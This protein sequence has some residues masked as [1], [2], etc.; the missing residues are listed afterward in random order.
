MDTMGM[1]LNAIRQMQNVL[2]LATLLMFFAVLSGCTPKKEIAHSRSFEEW[3]AKAETSQPSSP[4]APK[5]ELLLDDLET[6][7]VSSAAAL[8][9]EPNEQ[10]QEQRSL[11]TTS[12]SMTMRNTDVNVILRSLAQVTNQNMMMNDSVKG[13]AQINVQ[14]TPWDQVFKGIL[15]TQGLTYR[16]EGDILRVMSLSDLQHENKLEEVQQM[17]QA[18]ALSSKMV[19]PMLTKVIPLRF[20]SIKQLE[21]FTSIENT[22]NSSDSNSDS[23]DGDAD[24]EQVEK[25]FSNL[26]SKDKD[27]KSIGSVTADT[28]TNSIIV[29]AIRDD[30]IKIAKLVEELDRPTIQIQLE[31][32]IVETNKTTARELGIQWGALAHHNNNWVT[33][34]TNAGTLNNSVDTAVTPTLGQAVNLP[35]QLKD[36]AG[37]TLGLIN[38]NVGDYILNLQLS[39][40][41]EANKLH[42][43]SSPSITTLD[44]Q[45]AIIESG[46]TIPF[47]T[48]DAQSGNVNIQYK[49]ATLRLEVTPHVVDRQ[50]LK[51]MIIINK[52]EVDFSNTIQG[53]P[54]IIKKTAETNLILADGATTVIGGL[55]KETT[56]KSKQG[57]PFLQD[58]P[59]FGYLFKNHSDS[60]DM[61]EVMIF[62]TPHI[63]KTKVAAGQ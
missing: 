32:H 25:V 48:V 55:A 3:K 8:N 28:Q 52:D 26:L 51:L 34:G 16:W 4:T 41:E 36:G 54:T 29:H 19:E 47:Q 37:F 58:I 56:N 27:G 57:V 6:H 50:T 7:E 17:H 35:A 1:T 59:G 21:E 30:I 11:P 9:I 53:N 10:E 43:L 20:Y 15:R 5:R 14:N 60:N 33:A 24:K 39:A 12:V 46:K 13:L 22:S 18:Q 2:W 61:E 31:A 63:L 38:Q 44:N 45:M 42:I 62:I 49:D 40:L 23:S